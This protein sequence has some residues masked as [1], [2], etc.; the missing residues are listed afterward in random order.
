M[1]IINLTDKH[2]QSPYLNDALFQRLIERL[3]EQSSNV[4]QRQQIIILFIDLT[5]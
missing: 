5:H 3:I 2:Y 4:L 1:M